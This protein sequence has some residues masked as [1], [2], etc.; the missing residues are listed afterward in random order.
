M[1]VENMAILKNLPN[2]GERFCD[3]VKPIAVLLSKTRR[4]HGGKLDQFGGS[5]T[6]MVLI[7]E[8]ICRQFQSF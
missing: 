1:L 8:K 4:Q 5:S 3:K 2:I 6:E 7:R